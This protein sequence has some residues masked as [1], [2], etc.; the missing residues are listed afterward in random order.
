MKNSNESIFSKIKNY[1]SYGILFSMFL[2]MTSEVTAQEYHP[3]YVQIETGDDYGAGT[4]ARVFINLY[5][6]DGQTTWV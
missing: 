3:L 2:L 6:S 4:D 1:L 5:F